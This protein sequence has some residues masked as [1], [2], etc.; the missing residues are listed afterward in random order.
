MYDACTVLALRLWQADLVASEPGLK[1]RDLKK[2][3]KCGI[4]MRDLEAGEVERV[5]I[6]TQCT[7]S[8]PTEDS[9]VGSELL[10]CVW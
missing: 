9:C 6:Y 7:S 8:N 1:F 10:A 4:N 5:T 3:E 2:L